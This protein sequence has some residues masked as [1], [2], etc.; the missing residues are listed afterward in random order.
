MLTPEEASVIHSVPTRT[1]YRWVEAG[2]IH[3]I[4]TADRLLLVCTTSLSELL[5]KLSNMPERP[6]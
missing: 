5:G 1:I 6:H 3:S 2:L 4:E